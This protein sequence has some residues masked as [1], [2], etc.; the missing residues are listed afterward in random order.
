MI[1][2]DIRMLEPYRVEDAT[3]LIK[4]DAMENPY[5]MP[6]ALHE[7][8][9]QLLART[10]VH[11]YP[12]A[13]MA[14]LR[15]QIAELDGVDPAQILLGN[16]S[17]ELIQMIL[18]AADPGACAI[19]SPTF[20]MYELISRWLRR[21]V[22]TVAL[23]AHFELSAQKLLRT[24]GREKAAVI[25][26]ACP[27]NPTGNLWPMEEVEAV[28]RGFNGLVVIDEAYRPFTDRTHLSLIAPNVVI[29]RTFSKMGWAGL[30]LGY[31]I[32]DPDTIAQLNKVRLPY[33][34]NALTQASASF[35]LRHGELFAA[36]CR[37]IVEERER[38]AGILE[39]INGITL[40]PS[41]TN[42]LLI[43]VADAERTFSFLKSS[44]ILVRNLH[45]PNGPLAGC[46]RLTIGTPEENDALIR[47]LMQAV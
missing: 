24:S 43:R 28:A 23:D 15:A 9:Q 42:F 6:R 31:A 3:G 40:F 7:G 12:D 30:R 26:L 39:G 32:G 41:Q 22:V 13:D 5:P 8:W 37:R 36:Q 29:L 44:G 27:N 34:I 14:G 17:D 46:L 25:F 10:E 47:A 18:M 19:P 11:R 1:R 33:N 38:V 16:G 45:Q 35:L 20:S 21:P 4:L 2:K